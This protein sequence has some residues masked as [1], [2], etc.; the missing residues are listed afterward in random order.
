MDD[1]SGD[2]TVDGPYLFI[3]AVP[4]VLSGDFSKFV[5]LRHVVDNP[6]PGKTY[7]FTVQGGAFNDGSTNVNMSVNYDDTAVSGEQG[8]SRSRLEIKRI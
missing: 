6:E 5:V 1:G 7:S 2:V 4:G 8:V 3:E